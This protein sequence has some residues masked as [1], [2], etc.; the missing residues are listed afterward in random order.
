MLKLKKTIIICTVGIISI[1][2]FNNFEKISASEND[3]WSIIGTIINGSDNLPLPDHL[4]ILHVSLADEIKEYSS[5]SDENGVFLF[6]DINHPPDSIIGISS[7]YEGVLYGKDLGVL[8]DKRDE[9][10]LIVY[11]STSD[12]SEISIA[13]S[14]IM[15]TSI[16]RSQ[17]TMWVLELYK[18]KND[19]N[20]TFKPDPDKPMSIVRIGLPNDYT[21]LMIDSDMIGVE[22][23]AIDKGFGV[24]GNIYPGEHQLLFTYGISYKNS[25][26]NFKRNTQFDLDNLRIISE[27][28]IEL[29]LEDFEY[30]QQKTEVNSTEYN[31]IEI[32]NIPKTKSMSIKFTN[33]PNPSLY[34]SAVNFVQ[35]LNSGWLLLVL[36]LS[37]SM[38]LLVK[39]SLSKRSQV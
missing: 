22:F 15:F 2:I 10:K 20:Q 21:E 8:S 7:I 29:V 34:D 1:F 37:L 17:N 9:L 39:V 14:T 36:F 32:N 38:G 35:N 6:N 23:V 24:L 19:S 16:D 33:L 11:K 13:T 5:K 3:S 18:L 25:I 12:S 30:T 27:N 4:V 26:Y 28:S 31:L